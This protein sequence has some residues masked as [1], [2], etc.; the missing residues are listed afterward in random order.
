MTRLAADLSAGLVTSIM[1]VGTAS[2][3]ITTIDFNDLVHSETMAVDRYGSQGVAISLVG[4]SGTGPRAWGLN[5]DDFGTTGT[6]IWPATNEVAVD[7]GPFYSLQFDFAAP[8]DWFSI[9]AIDAEES[10]AAQAFLSGTRVVVGEQRTFLGNY[11]TFNPYTGTTIGGDIFELTLGAVGSALLF[12]RV[13]VSLDAS[14]PEGW[15]NLSFNVVPL[16]PTFWLLTG[17]LASVGAWIRRPR[18]LEPA[19][20]D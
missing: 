19:A 17:A 2:A 7:D 12:D 1:I 16:P 20:V 10:Y 15:D 4:L 9:V 14:G 11:R 13:I 6:V 18:H 5:L 3:S 8:I